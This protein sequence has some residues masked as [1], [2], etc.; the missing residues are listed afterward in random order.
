MQTFLLKEAPFTAEEIRALRETSDRLG[1]NILYA[2]QLPGE[3]AAPMP[4]DWVD[5][6]ET[7]DYPRL[8]LAADRQKFYDDYPQDIRPT[9]DDRPFFFHTTKLEGSVPGRVR[10]V[11]AVRQRPER[12]A[13]AD[14]HF[15]RRSSCC[16]SSG[17]LALVGVG[18][19]RRWFSWLLY[20]GALGAGFMLI[21]VSVL[22]RFVLLLGHPVYSLTVTLF[23]LLL[24]TGIGAAWSRRLDDATLVR[25]TTVMLVVIAGIG[26]AVVAVGH[27]PGHLGD[28]VFAPG[29]HRHR[30]RDARADRRGAGHP[31]AGRHPAAACPGARR[32]S[33][34]RGESTGRCRCS[35]P[36]WRSSSP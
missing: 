5:G 3:P 11:D 25:S 9:T 10:Q 36:R 8:I 17:P 7:A 31:D 6:M 29:P 16:S 19:A 2:P 12:A 21:E 18:G 13:D 14:G 35:G 33:P 28:P 22:Q 32:W 15:R 20:F 23:S 30:R 26:L 27:A 1:F 34:G 24:G 4:T